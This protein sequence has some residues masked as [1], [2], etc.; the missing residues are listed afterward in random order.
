MEEEGGGGSDA[1]WVMGMVRACVRNFVQMH[2][3]CK[4]T[5]IQT[6][7]RAGSAIDAIGLTQLDW[8]GSHKTKRQ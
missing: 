4:A 6:H 5:K 1:A 8:L 2:C 3:M 7:T